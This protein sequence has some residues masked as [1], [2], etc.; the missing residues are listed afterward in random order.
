MEAGTVTGAGKLTET[1][2]SKRS[3]EVRETDSSG[4]YRDM[5]WTVR[6]LET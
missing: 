1:E 4:L 6:E 5:D 3:G 2:I